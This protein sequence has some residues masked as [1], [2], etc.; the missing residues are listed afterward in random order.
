M[1]T[2]LQ[3]SLLLTLACVALSPVSA[4]GVFAAD[5]EKIDMPRMR[6]QIRVLESVLNQNLTQTFPG[7]FGYLDAAHGVY[8]PGYGV[9]FSFEINLSQSPAS[10]GQFG[11]GRPASAAA[12]HE[13]ETKRREQAKAM[14]Q[15]VLADFGPTLEQLAP[16]ESVGIVIHCSTITDRGVEKSTIVLRAQKHDVDDFR[17]SK[18][19]RTAFVSKLQLLEY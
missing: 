4:A 14:A 12:R 8:L 13:E 10:L 11:G 17:A 2:F 18:L 9:V 16:S 15:R 6:D 3:I 7:P 1:K 5:N 19:D